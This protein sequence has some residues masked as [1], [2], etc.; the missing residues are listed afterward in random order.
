MFNYVKG[1]LRS[2]VLGTCIVSLNSEYWGF[3][4]VIGM[5]TLIGVIIEIKN[6]KK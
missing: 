5:L 6:L 3:P 1:L 2:I 4:L